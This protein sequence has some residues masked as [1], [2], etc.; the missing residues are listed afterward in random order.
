M[1]NRWFTVIAAWLLLWTAWAGAG[2]PTEQLKTTVDEVLKIVNSPEF[3]KKTQD[4][5][6]LLKKAVEPRFDFNEMSKR[7]LGQHWRGMNTEE[8]QEFVKL[9]T[10]FL[11]NAYS[12]AIDSYRYQGEKVVFLKEKVDD[13]YADIE[14]KILKGPKEFPVGYRMH[15]AEDQW[16]VYDVTIEGVSIVNN[17]RSQFAKIL[18]NASVAELLTRLR[19]KQKDLLAQ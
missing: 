9:F 18:A 19:T 5:R 12:A 14:T 2:E 10:D 13:S 1:R 15:R 17:F 3:N 6:K 16:K 7:A 4:R 8:R 11:E